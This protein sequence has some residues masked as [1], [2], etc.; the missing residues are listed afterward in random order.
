VGVV[1][2]VGVIVDVDVVLLAWVM[3]WMGDGD[4]GGD[5]G[6]EGK[7]GEGEGGRRLIHTHG[8]GTGGGAHTGICIKPDLL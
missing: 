3:R 2:G 6:V 1:V 4:F 7:G 8:P 5:D